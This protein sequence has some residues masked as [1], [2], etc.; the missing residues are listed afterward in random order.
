MVITRL[1]WPQMVCLRHKLKSGLRSRSV[2]DIWAASQVAIRRL[3]LTVTTYQKNL[4]KDGFQNPN[5]PKDGFHTNLPKGA[6]QKNL[7]QD[8]FQIKASPKG[9]HAKVS[10]R[11]GSATVSQQ[12]RNV[13]FG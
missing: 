8:G 11:S 5:L 3:R 4:S 9:W 1:R 13:A 12:L 7:S 10:G 2:E 6:Y